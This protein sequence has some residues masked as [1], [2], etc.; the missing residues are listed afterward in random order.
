MRM[1]HHRMRCECRR[2]TAGL[3]R[4]IDTGRLLCVFEF[5]VSGHRT[6]SVAPVCACSIWRHM[7]RREQGQATVEYAVTFAALI[8]P[9]TAAIIFT[10]QLLWIWHSVVDFTRDGARYATTHCWQGAGENVIAYMRTNVPAMIDRDQFQQGTAEIA[11]E[12]FSR[13]V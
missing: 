2:Q 3:H 11:V 4:C 8:M 5:S 9:M 7:K 12:Y 6:D 13:N 10:A 1:L